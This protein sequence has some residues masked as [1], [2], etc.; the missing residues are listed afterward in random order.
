MTA[1]TTRNQ[2]SYI[3]LHT[4]AGSTVDNRVILTSDLVTSGSMHA[5]HLPWSKCCLNHPTHSSANASMGIN[6]K[7]T[8]ISFNG[9]NKHL[10]LNQDNAKEYSLT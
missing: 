3:D 7:L 4:C 5:Q 9:T 8:F 6:Y 1:H 10:I 2:S